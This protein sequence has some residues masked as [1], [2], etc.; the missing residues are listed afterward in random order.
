MKDIQA[1]AE[2]MERCIHKYNQVEN[3]KFSYGSN[4]ELTRN[5][6]H[7]INFIGKNEGINVTE[8]AKLKGITKGAVSQMIY[9]LV[10]KGFVTK[11]ISPNSDTEVQLELTDL[12]WSA[13]EAHRKYHQEIHEEFFGLLNTMPDEAYEMM[14]EVARAFEQ[15]I[16]RRLS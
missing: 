14:M 10:E 15:T 1:C 6:I 11:R 16:D 7:T 5:E 4:I 12:G 13:Y 8:L 9:K 3:K 2:L